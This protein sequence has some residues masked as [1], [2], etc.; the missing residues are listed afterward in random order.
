MPVQSAEI[1]GVAKE[2]AFG[3][4][5][6]PSGAEIKAGKAALLPGLCTFN[7]TTKVA[8]PDQSRGVRDYVVD[9]LVGIEAGATIT[10]EIIPGEGWGLLWGA[11]FGVASD[12]V[13]EANSEGTTK[14]TLVPKNTVPSLSLEVD[15]DITSQALARKLVGCTVD[16]LV[17]RGTAQALAT[18]EATLMA[19]REA[20][21]ASPTEETPSNLG[22]TP[23]MPYSQP[24]DH[25]KLKADF[26]N[27]VTKAYEELAGTAGAAGSSAWADNGL[28]DYTLT[29]MNHIQRVFVSNKQLYPV[30]LVPTRREVQFQ[31]TLDFLN[32]NAYDAWVAGEWIG[33]AGNPAIKLKYLQDALSN[34]IQ[35]K[36]GSVEFQ[37]ARLRA[38][39]QFNLQSASD[40][41]NQQITWSTVLGPESNIVQMVV[42][43]GLGN[44]TTAGGTSEVY[45]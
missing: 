3:T 4:F 15:H 32:A 27:M 37:I 17:F 43:D 35:T 44:G 14:H 8:R 1:I 29:L 5:A 10:G 19:Q 23:A 12:T 38:Q 36:P 11:W 2:S 34:R 33:S 22:A 26:Y 6:P 28:Q 30:R 9:A 18:Q 21:N 41:L 31:T 7:T 45:A 42:V 24:F 25:A 39:G 16:Q 40:V 20:T 13:S